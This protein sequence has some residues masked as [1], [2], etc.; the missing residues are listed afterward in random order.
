MPVGSG[1]VA[2]ADTEQFTV[3]HGHDVHLGGSA[4]R[5]WPVTWLNFR[6]N[7]TNHLRLSQSREDAPTP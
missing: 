1:E 5:V 2:I 7:D 6:A 4:R 3:L